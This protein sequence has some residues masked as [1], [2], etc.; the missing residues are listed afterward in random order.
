MSE[1]GNAFRIPQFLEARTRIDLVRAMLFNNLAHGMEF[2]YF[3]IQKD[4][5]VWIAWYR[6]PIDEKTFIVEQFTN[7]ARSQTG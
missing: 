7:E 6:W 4:G 1:V 5:K 3:G 2:D